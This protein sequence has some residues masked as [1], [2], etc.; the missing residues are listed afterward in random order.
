MS[1]VT[2]GTWLKHNIVISRFRCHIKTYSNLEKHKI[3]FYVLIPL[4]CFQGTRTETRI[5]F[6]SLFYVIVWAYFSIRR[7]LWVILTNMNKVK[8]RVSYL[9]NTADRKVALD[10]WMGSVVVLIVCSYIW[11]EKTWFLT[12][13]LATRNLP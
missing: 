5:I 9:E 3:Y 4:L 13:L 11:A 10:H 2:S 6:D 12:I 7:F 8:C 1:T